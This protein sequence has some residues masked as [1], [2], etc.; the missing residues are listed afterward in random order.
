MPELPEVETTRRGIAPF[1]EGRTICR[2]DI[3]ENRLR[4]E[5]PPDL[6]QRLLEQKI[7]RVNRRGKYLLLATPVGTLIIHLGMSGSLRI[8]G[9]RDLP[10]KHDHIDFVFSNSIVLRFNDP[11]KFGAVLFTEELPERHPL[12]SS[13]GLEPLADDFDGTYLYQQSRQ[14]K[15]AVKA[16]I[17]NAGIVVGVGNIYANESLYLAGIRPSRAAGNI[18]LQRYQRLAEAIK[19]VL[20]R[21]IELGG[22][23]LR[24]F[25]NEQGRPGYFQQS[26]SVYGREGQACRHCATLISQSRIA[27]RSSF[28]CP[29]CQ[30]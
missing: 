10:R 18:S 1:I 4:W 29:V 27:Q 3:R 12:L 25:V 13:L 5:V 30:T 6:S 23:T 2:V 22:T 28:F 14:R 15:C 20:I 16:F 17:M 8:V 26:L 21:S 24:D 11:R 7:L 19:A 9:D